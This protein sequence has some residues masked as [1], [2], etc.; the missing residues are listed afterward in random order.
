MAWTETESSC[1]DETAVL[2]DECGWRW[3]LKRQHVLRSHSPIMSAVRPAVH[4][5]GILDRVDVVTSFMQQGR[6]RLAR[7]CPAA[8]LL[9]AKAATSA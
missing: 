7:T 2:Q 9:S 6:D 4:E 5:Q 1:R 8:F 3:R